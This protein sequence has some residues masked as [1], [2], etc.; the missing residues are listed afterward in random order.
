MPDATSRTDEM[1]TA[2]LSGQHA[3]LDRFTTLTEDRDIEGKQLAEAV[4]ALEIAR[5]AAD[6]DKEL[7]KKQDDL[8]HSLRQQLAEARVQSRQNA[9]ERD[10]LRAIKNKQHAAESALAQKHLEL[11]SELDMAKKMSAGLG[12]E[13]VGAR[14]ALHAAEAERDA[15]A[16]ALGEAHG[17]REALER[18]VIDL[19]HQV[20]SHQARRG[21]S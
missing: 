7:V 14:S 19:R 11:Q 9:T 16:S 3:M 4:D 21:N 1:F 10:E 8:I 20:S 6:R 5:A 12:D 13:L 17:C 18:D 2:L 15:L